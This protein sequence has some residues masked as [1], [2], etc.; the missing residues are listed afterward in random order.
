[1]SGAAMAMT[2]EM[3]AQTWSRNWATWR[4]VGWGCQLGL[5]CK[6]AV[7][8]G[9]EAMLLTMTSQVKN[10]YQLFWCYKILYRTDCVVPQLH[11]SQNAKAKKLTRKLHGNHGR[12]RSGLYHRLWAV[13]ACCPLPLLVDYCLLCLYPP[14]LLCP[15]RNCHHHRCRRCCCLRCRCYHCRCRLCHCRHCRCRHCR[16]C[17]CCHHRCCRHSS[18]CRHRRNCP[19]PLP[20]NIAIS[21]VV[22]A[23]VRC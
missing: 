1:M 20:Q 5:L 10:G 16:R 4:H 9:T 3:S 18:H 23:C 14:L 12:Q 2:M 7:A 6:Q 8:M 15:S 22:V 11:S 17:D 21:V 19:P 13:H